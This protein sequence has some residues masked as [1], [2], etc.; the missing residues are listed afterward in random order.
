MFFVVLFFY[1]CFCLFFSPVEQ[2]LNKYD[3]C[4][5]VPSHFLRSSTSQQFYRIAMVK[6]FVKIV[7]T[8]GICRR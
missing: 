8:P 1:S 4:L 6:K 2:S 3:L 7:G 5:L